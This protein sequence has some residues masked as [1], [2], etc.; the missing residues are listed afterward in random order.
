MSKSRRRRNRKETKPVEGTRKQIAKKPVHIHPELA[1]YVIQ[2]KPN[3]ERQVT[4]D[5]RRIGLPYY[6][7]RLLFEIVRRGKKDRIERG[8]FPGYV[9]VGLD[10]VSPPLGRIHSVQGVSSLVGVDG[11]PFPVPTAALMRWEAYCCE[12]AKEAVP[13]V[14]GDFYRITEGVM[15]G[16]MAQ[17]VAVMSGDRVRAMVELFGGRTAVELPTE[18][19]AA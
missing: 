10:P 16:F 11:K 1:Y 9:F 13:I 4:D 12:G 17:V 7:P 15:D 3:R 8:L 14:V 5:L 6:Y 18:A 19:L 2:T